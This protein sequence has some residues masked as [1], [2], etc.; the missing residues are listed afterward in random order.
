MCLRFGFDDMSYKSSSVHIPQ[1]LKADYNYLC[2]YI[3][4]KYICYYNSPSFNIRKEQ[5]DKDLSS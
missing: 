1:T 2:N 4:I 3:Y 5:Q